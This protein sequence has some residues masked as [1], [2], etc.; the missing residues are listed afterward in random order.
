[1]KIIRPITITDAMLIDSNVPENDYPA[2]NPATTYVGGDRV[3]IAAQHKVYESLPAS[4]IELLTLDVA[5]A[6]P[7]LPNWTLTGQTSGKTCVVVQCLTSTTYLVKDRSGEFALDEVIGVTGTASLLA[8]QGP[9]N[10]TF[11]AQ[12]NVGHDPVTDCARTTP[13][14]WK[15]VS[16]TNRWK[17]YDQKV[18]SQTARANTI[19]YRLS[20]GQVFDAIAF[21]NLEATSI[22]IVMTDPVAGEVY[23]KTVSLVSTAITGPDKVYDWYSY[24][25]S[26]YFWITDLA[27]LDI[28]PYLNAVL[29]ITIAYTDGTA[30]VGGIVLGLQANIGVTQ[31]SPSIG[32]HDYS[33]KTVDD[34]GVYSVEERAFSKRISCDVQ[35]QN[36][37][38]DNIQNLLSRI[39]ATPVVWIAIERYSSLI[40]YGYY[41][42]F[43]IVIPRDTRSDCSLEIEGLT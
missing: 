33:I 9:A 27:R 17:A 42:D 25:F 39:R 5:P 12:A 7:W 3:I 35:I 10:P 8:D 22:Q 11:A 34:Y 43:Q 2:Y 28:T 21:L 24:F 14:W 19:T 18:G 26:S 23:N 32:I 40:V 31:Y 1:M 15:E 13:L 38:L 16:A 29:D 41:K 4:G 30:K 6:V 20:P 37:W 36:A